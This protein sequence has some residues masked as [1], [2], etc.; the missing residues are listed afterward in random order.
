MT[1]FEPASPK[2]SDIST[3]D[4]VT[5]KGKDYAVASVV[6]TTNHV[7]GTITAVITITYY[8]NP[9]QL[10]LESKNTVLSSYHIDANDVYHAVW[11]Q[12]AN[13]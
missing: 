2:L 3:N 12:T 5:Y 8:G 4:K 13:A 11:V 9:V 10:T 7:G 1:N 6:S